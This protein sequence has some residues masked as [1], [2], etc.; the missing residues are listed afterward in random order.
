MRW[1]PLV[2]LKPAQITQVVKLWKWLGT[3][4]GTVHHH[5]CECTVEGAK[6]GGRFGKQ[7]RNPASELQ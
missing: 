5:L 2:P 6:S 7:V 4:N 1:P 3:E